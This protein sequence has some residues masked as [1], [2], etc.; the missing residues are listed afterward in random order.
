MCEQEEK[1]RRVDEF[2]ADVQRMVD[3]C[4]TYNE[5]TNPALVRPPAHPPSP[6]SG[7]SRSSPS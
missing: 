4:R 6:L 7:S 3:N 2:R 5:R 1:Y